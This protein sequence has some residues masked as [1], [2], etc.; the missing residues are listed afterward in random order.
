MNKNIPLP[1]WAKLLPEGSFISYS[2]TYK[3]GEY[4]N[5]FHKDSFKPSDFDSLTFYFFDPT[6]HGYPKD[7]A[8][9]LI[10]FL[11]GTS[12]ALEGD[13]CINYAG[14]EFYA[15]EEYQKALGGAYLLVPL[16]NE[17]RSEEGRVRGG[18]SE[19][20][21]KALYELI[22]A[23]INNQ[24]KGSCTKNILIGNSAGAWMTFN[25]GNNYTSFFDIL[26]PVGACEIPDDK[27][28]D[29]YDQENVSLFYAIGKHDELNDFDTLVRPRLPRLQA[30]KNC[31]IYTPEWVQNGDKGVASINFGHEMG[32]HCLVNP[33]HCN[34]MFDDGTPMEPRLP[35]GVTGWIAGLLK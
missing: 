16:A 13:V 17:Y 24:M 11:H 15:K 8:Y 14:G 19:T 6:E 31:F 26:I 35:N 7:R 18:W 28:L 22:S 29:R 33:M 21:T 2:P 32:Q 5:R 10:T 23:F 4:F 9:P 27:M 1:P 30:M 34:L 25:M 3:V 20:P 12:N